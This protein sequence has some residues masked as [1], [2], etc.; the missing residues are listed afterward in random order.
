MTVNP[1]AENTTKVQPT[2]PSPAP[3]GVPSPDKTP[4]QVAQ[5]LLQA[6]VP[7]TAGID[8][9]TLQILMQMM[10]PA[11]AEMARTMAIELRKPTPEEAQKIEA[12]KDRILNARK[13]AAASGALETAVIKQQQAQCPHMKPNGAHTF[14]GQ[15]HSN[16]WATIKC[17][18]CL[19][20]FVVRP[21]PEHIQ[22]GLN[23]SD[24]TGLTVQHLEAWQAN[25]K[26]IDE[27]LRKSQEAMAGMSAGFA[28]M[29]P[30][31]L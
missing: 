3:P 18:R 6:R 22:N 29:T 21:L 25:S 14:R 9:A 13:A 27:Q 15:V 16:G 4:Q 19:R 7:Q 26:Q 31:G 28:N 10:M 12:E 2:Q 8:P 11:V 30:A 23:L 24:I 5:E 20:P 17:Q 1:N